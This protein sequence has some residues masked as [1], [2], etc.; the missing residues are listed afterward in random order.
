[1]K[2]LIVL[3]LLLL[4]LTFSTSALAW[5][6]PDMWYSKAADGPPNGMPGGGGILGTGGAGDY[7]ITC[8]NCHIKGK[9]PTGLIDIKVDFNPAILS[10]MYK[11]GQSYAV[12]VTMTGEHLGLSGCGQYTPDNNNF[13]SVAIEDQNG[14]V[15]GDLRADYGSTSS[16]PSTAGFQANTFKGTFLSNDCHAVLSHGASMTQWTFNWTAPKSGTGPVTV[17][18]GSVDG[19]CSMDS[20]NDDVKVGTRQL[21]EGMAMRDEAPSGIAWAAMLPLASIL[22]SITKR[23][24][25]K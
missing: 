16:C 3:P 1:M 19:D 24:R 14:K 23:L 9:N 18:Y 20:L 13:V 4:A 22:R 5:D 2:T 15:A 11:P 10:S 17:Y 25:R 7:N 12:T 8:A 21:G 6:G